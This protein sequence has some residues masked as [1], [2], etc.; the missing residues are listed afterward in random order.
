MCYLGHSD[1]D[2]RWHRDSVIMRFSGPWRRDRISSSSRQLIDGCDARS[3]REG[4]GV[5]NYAVIRSDRFHR[6][7]IQ[8]DQHHLLDGRIPRQGLSGRGRSHLPCRHDPRGLLDSLRL[9]GQE[10]LVGAGAQIHHAPGDSG[11]IGGC[12]CYELRPVVLSASRAGGDLP[13]GRHVPLPLDDSFGRCLRVCASRTGRCCLRAAVGTVPARRKPFEMATGILLRIPVLRG[14]RGAGGEPA[15]EIP[16][17]ARHR[18]C[19][20]GSAANA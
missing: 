13:R 20:G 11:A 2:L 9:F 14:G 12:G 8:R 10:R 19:D 6:G 15:G 3:D 4:A 1:L 17:V 18:F 5:A 7:W 16:F